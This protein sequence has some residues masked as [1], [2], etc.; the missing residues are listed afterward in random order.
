[1]CFYSL[2]SHGDPSLPSDLRNPCT[3]FIWR[4][5]GTSSLLAASHTPVGTLLTPMV[6]KASATY[7]S[8]CAAGIHPQPALTKCSEHFSKKR[9]RRRHKKLCGKIGRQHSPSWPRK[10]RQQNQ[11]LQTP[12]SPKMATSRQEVAAITWPPS[13]P[14]PELKTTLL[15]ALVN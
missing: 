14:K 11:S 2:G 6:L 10:H 1:M 15:A 8:A 7:S 3:K 13:R 5:V 12:T 9:C 4:S